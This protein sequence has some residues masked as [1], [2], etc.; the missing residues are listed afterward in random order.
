MP[1]SPV[2]PGGRASA[3]TPPLW[4]PDAD[5][6]CGFRARLPYAKVAGVRE[7]SEEPV[8]PARRATRRI[9][10]RDRAAPRRSFV[11]SGQLRVLDVATGTV[12]LLT[13]S[14]GSESLS[15]FA[16]AGFEFSPDG[17]RILFSRTEEDG[18]GANSLWSVNVDGSNLRRLVTGTAWGDWLS[19]SP[20]R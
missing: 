3:L 8:G 6:G 13:E 20:T 4:R 17:D 1:R 16:G 5:G 12:T 2:P 11:S 15:V 7:I 9:A 10:H 14:E 18:T 19:P